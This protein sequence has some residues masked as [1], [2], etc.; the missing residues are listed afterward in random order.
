MS[1]KGD[2]FTTMMD[3]AGKHASATTNLQLNT[4]ATD[5]RGGVRGNNHVLVPPPHPQEQQQQ[6]QQQ[7]NQ[8]QR[9]GPPRSTTNKSALTKAQNY[10][11][12]SRIARHQEEMQQALQTQQQSNPRPPMPPPQL[13]AVRKQRVITPE[14]MARRP[15]EL[16]HNIMMRSRHKSSNNSVSNSVTTDST[17]QIQNTK[18]AIAKRKRSTKPQLLMERKEN[19]G[20]SFNVNGGTNGYHRNSNDKHAALAQLVAALS[21]NNGR[22]EKLADDDKTSSITDIE[23]TV[24]SNAASADNSYVPPETEFKRSITANS[25]TSKDTLKTVATEKF[26]R[27]ISTKS[28]LTQLVAASSVNSNEKPADDDETSSITDVAKTLSNYTASANSSSVPQVTEFKRSITTNSDISKDSLITMATEKFKRSISTKSTLTQLVATLSVNNGRNEKPADD[29]KT[30]SITDDEKT[31]SNNSASAISSSVPPATEFMR[32]ITATSDISKDSLITLATEKIMRS[33]STKSTLAQLV[34]ALSVNNGRNEKLA[35]NDKTSSITDVARTLS[36]NTASAISSS[37]PPATEF[38]RSI[39]ANSDISKDTLITV[40]TEEFMRSI[41]PK[42]DISKDSLITEAE[43]M[44]H[45]SSPRDNHPFPHENKSSIDS[46]RVTAQI[47]RKTNNLI[48]TKRELRRDLMINTE[49]QPA[50]AS[51]IFSPVFKEDVET[52][53]STLASEA[54]VPVQAAVP[55]RAH[56]PVQA[57]SP[58][59]APVSVPEEQAASKFEIENRTVDKDFVALHKDATSL[60]NLEQ[61]NSKT[62]RLKKEHSTND[63]TPSHVAKVESKYETNDSVEGKE[64]GAS[65]EYQDVSE[66]LPELSSLGKEKSPEANMKDVTSDQNE[67]E[68]PPEVARLGSAKSP[69]INNM[70]GRKGKKTMTL[71]MEPNEKINPGAV[72]ASKTKAKKMGKSNLALPKSLSVFYNKSNVT[73]EE[74]EYAAEEVFTEDDDGEVRD[75]PEEISRGMVM[76]ARPLVGKNA[77]KTKDKRMG[78]SN[79]TL[80]RTSSLPVKKSKESKK[81][82]SKRSTLLGKKSK[83]IEEER[84]YAYEEEEESGVDEDEDGRDELEERNHVKRHE[85]E[86]SKSDCSMSMKSSEDNDGEARDE[87]EEISRGMAMPA[88]PLLGKNAKTKYERTGKSNMTLPR[89]SSLPGKK[90]KES[91]KMIPKRSTLLGKKSKVIEEERE[92]A[93]EQEEESGVDEDEDGRDE[94]EETNHVKR[95][96]EESS[97]GDRSMSMKSTLSNAEFISVESSITTDH[98]AFVGKPGVLKRTASL[99]RNPGRAL[100]QRP[101]VMADKEGEELMKSM[102]HGRIAARADNRKTERTKG[103]HIKHN[104]CTPDTEEMYMMDHILIKGNA[105]MEDKILGQND[106]TIKEIDDIIYNDLTYDVDSMYEDNNDDRGKQTQMDEHGTTYPLGTTFPII[107]N[108]SSDIRQIP[109]SQSLKEIATQTSNDELCTPMF[110]PTNGPAGQ[111]IS[112]DFVQY[113]PGKIGTIGHIMESCAFFGARVCMGTSKAMLSCVD[114]CNDDPPGTKMAVLSPRHNAAPAPHLRPLAPPAKAD[115]RCIIQPSSLNN[116]AEHQPSSSNKST[117]Q[118]VA[119]I[120]TRAFAMALNGTNGGNICQNQE[121]IFLKAPLRHPNQQTPIRHPNQHVKKAD[122]FDDFLSI[123]GLF[124]SSKHQHQQRLKSVPQNIAVKPKKRWHAVEI[125]KIKHHAVKTEVRPRKQVQIAENEMKH[126]SDQIDELRELT[127][128]NSLIRSESNGN[129][130]SKGVRKFFNKIGRMRVGFM[131]EV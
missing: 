103:N 43:I 42:S 31:L 73:E 67:S 22:S 60:K 54:Q 80:P 123:D 64:S 21:V 13:K 112:D 12:A 130:T 74:V 37:V 120:F 81:T 82:I 61:S 89:R 9:E 68:T 35:D 78:K 124:V 91:K 85:E 1:R 102:N 131:Y 29:D 51:S 113:P 76:P 48:P 98:E 53:I 46:D 4:I 6:N 129:K 88:R 39:T 27:S 62:R 106:N 16:K 128:T 18:T 44:H 79:M 125:D 69:T 24:S 10:I 108:V 8:Q 19:A 94:L 7:Q 23:K 90:S 70:D 63:D 101:R 5:G 34:A 25:D 122:N 117:E 58:A 99:V 104:D 56:S 32:P 75:E 47:N 87:P 97:E 57:P 105:T 115:Q 17:E 49:L 59:P 121:Q 110:S 45:P 41:S 30:S 33:I 83:V 20:A 40:A 11:M 84:K 66:A 92:Y 96:E 107:Q 2:V 109:S 72:T 93:Y 28:T 14:M 26:K 100:L 118:E 77:D 3:N 86:S 50:E 38:K 95:H 65:D 15:V 71:D 111:T 126:P 55:A 114:A 116:N 119:G 36:N 52:Q 127:R